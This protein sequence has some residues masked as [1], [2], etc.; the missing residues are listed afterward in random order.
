MGAQAIWAQV[1]LKLELPSPVVQADPF[2]TRPRGLWIQT[3]RVPIDHP[4]QFGNKSAACDP[5]A[6][7]QRH[8]C[9]QVAWIWPKESPRALERPTGPGKKRAV[10]TGCCHA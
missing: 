9:T 4:P 10:A 6:G 3:A 8:A 5:P 2:I 1:L 7:A